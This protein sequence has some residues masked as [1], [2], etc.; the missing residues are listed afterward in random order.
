MGSWEPKSTRKNHIM[1]FCRGQKS[2]TEVL[3]EPWASVQAHRVLGHYIPNLISAV[4]GSSAHT[5]GDT[6]RTGC[7]IPAVP[8]IA[9]GQRESLV[10]STDANIRRAATVPFQETAR[11]SAGFNSPQSNQRGRVPAAAVTQAEQKS[12]VL[13]GVIKDHF[14]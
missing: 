14:G 4:M 6:H 2:Q 13:G 10:F 9:E 5:E 3:K 7:A 1:S 11:L 8:E 12:T